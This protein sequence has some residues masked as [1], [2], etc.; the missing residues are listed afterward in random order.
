MAKTIVSNKKNAPKI[1]KSLLRAQTPP[2]PPKAPLPW[3]PLKAAAAP[4]PGVS[5]TLA[6][7]QISEL[8]QFTK[9]STY[10]SNAS[11]MFHLFYVGRD[12]VHEILKYVLSRV[13]VSL[14]LN[15]Y[16]FDDQELNDIIFAKAT[17]PTITVLITLDKSQSGNATEQTLLAS[18]IAKNPA[19]YNTHFVIGDSS[20]GQ[21]THTKGFVAD[22]K[23]A[24]EGSTNWSKTGEGI[25]LPG[26]IQA[27]GTGYKAQNNT[28]SIIMDP[29]TVSR[30]AA[31]L[32]AEHLAAQVYAQ[33]NPPKPAP[34]QTITAPPQPTTTQ[35]IKRS[36]K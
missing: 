23:V 1:P 14:F 6:T 24:G 34:P 8:A 21:I 22:G 2:A 32:I 36:S 35:K 18:D 27:G 17:D 16:S 19:A 20:T 26:S 15:M 12:N 29:D 31:E 30:F 28:Q 9:E 7:F 33:N 10:D 13:T 3:N 4:L 5:Q 11:T 25:Y